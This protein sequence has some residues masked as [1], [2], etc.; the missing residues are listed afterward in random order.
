MTLEGAGV[1]WSH[2]A[3]R[4]G[5]VNSGLLEISGPIA[6]VDCDYSWVP[7]QLCVAKTIHIYPLNPNCFGSIAINPDIDTDEIHFDA[8]AR[9]EEGTMTAVT[10]LPV[11]DVTRKMV[12]DED[13]MAGL[14]LQ[15][16]GDPETYRRVGFFYTKKAHLNRTL[17]N[18]SR[19]TVALI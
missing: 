5:Q 3:A 9:F 19:H 8:E 14:V 16:T 17:K 11:V 4:F 13:I 2:Q 1:T 18:M 6:L 15:S 7:G 12:G 10:I